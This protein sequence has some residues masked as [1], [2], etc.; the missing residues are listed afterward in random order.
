MADENKI[1]DGTFKGLKVRIASGDVSGGRKKVAHQFPNRDTSAIEDMGGKPREFQLNIIVSGTAGMDYFAYRDKLLASLE[2]KGSGVLEHPLYGRIEDVECLS[3]SLSENFGEFGRST[4][5]ANFAINKNTGIPS[6]TNTAIS[7]LVA[8][9]EK[10]KKSALDNIK[11]KFKVS[12]KLKGNFDKATKK[13]GGVVAQAKE[14]TK[15]IG[16]V[17]TEISQITRAINGMS[18]R[19]NALAV[20]PGALADEVGGLFDSVQDFGGAIESKAKTMAGFF[21]LSSAKGKTDTAARVE[22][23][24]NNDTIDGAINS[25]ALGYSYTNTAQ[26]E[27]DTVAEVDQ[28][29]DALEAQYQ[30]VIDSDADQGTKDALTDLR[31]LSQELLDQQRLTAKQIIDVRTNITSARL[32][33]FQYYGSSAD[34]EALAK[35]NNAA[36]SSFIEGQVKVFTV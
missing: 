16:D 25:I 22:A 26:I 11:D 23:K 8:A 21:G 31:A 32:L 5:S 27:F 19:I 35:L 18:A 1:I 17:N 20:D 4:V 14:A 2:S 34:G 30:D 7:Q 10:V 13:I 3:W 9:N 28:A 12:P 15:F 36:D 24:R 6:Q 29:A 33:A